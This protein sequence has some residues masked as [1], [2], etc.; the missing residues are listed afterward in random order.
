MHFKVPQSMVTGDEL[1]RNFCTLPQALRGLAP[2][3]TVAVVGGRAGYDGKTSEPILLEKIAKAQ[4]AYVGSRA[5]F[6]K[7]AALI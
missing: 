1:R 5:D 2:G 4:G 3:G 7:M 6:R